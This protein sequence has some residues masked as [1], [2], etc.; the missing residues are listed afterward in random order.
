MKLEKGS[1]KPLNQAVSGL[2]DLGSALPSLFYPIR[3]VT[4]CKTN[5]DGFIQEI[6]TAQDTQG[7]VQVMNAQEVV[8]KYEGQ[9]TWKF[10][11]LHCLPGMNLKP[12]DIVSINGTRY[13]CMAKEDHTMY[14]FLRYDLAEDYQE[15]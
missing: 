4:I 10:F 2:P 15:S 7:V 5:V 1:L 13:R 14:G 8:I 6:E 11:T 12:D 9:R 3:A